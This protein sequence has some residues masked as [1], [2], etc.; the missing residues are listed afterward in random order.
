MSSRCNSPVSVTPTCRSPESVTP[1]C[2]NPVIVYGI[3]PRLAV[4]EEGNFDAVY[5][6]SVMTPSSF[7]YTLKN[8]GDAP[9][10]WSV[11]ADEGWVNFDVTS[12]TLLPG[13]ST[14]VT[15]TL[16]RAGL[17]TGV[18]SSTMTFSNDTDGVGSTT[19][20]ASLDITGAVAVSMSYRTKGGTAQLIGHS[21]FPDA[22]ASSPP[23]KYRKKT[24]TGTLED[25][26]S[27]S[28]G[29]GGSKSSAKYVYSGVASYDI[30]TGALTNTLNL[31]TYSTA[32]SCPAVDFIGNT[33]QAANWGDGTVAS[34]TCVQTNTI[35][36]TKVLR[37]RSNTCCDDL[38]IAGYSTFGSGSMNWELTEEDLEA[39][40]I[41]RL[42]NGGSW[43]SWAAIAAIGTAK[44]NYE[45]RTT[46]FTFAY[47]LAQWKVTGAGLLP[48]TLYYGTADVYRRVYGSG[49]AWV[50]MGQVTFSVISDLSGNLTYS[51][52]LAGAVGYEYTIYNAQ[53]VT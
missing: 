38:P 42:L 29:C 7:V 16:T 41:D 9:L 35:T 25:C 34:S 47:Q 33:A 50:S 21:E 11:S 13:Q 39:D 36:K 23:K 15:V 22:G 19:R 6:N 14:Q 45:Q 12:G 37:T 44:T 51:A 3:S 46:L 8:R 10:D 49:G 53:V 20:E 48:S 27:T 40:A 26:V 5:E 43:S 28:L 30:L 2:N 18:S 24:A 31:A 32:G 17:P 1:T 4:L 52:D